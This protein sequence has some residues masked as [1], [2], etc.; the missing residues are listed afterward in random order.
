L[1]KSKPYII[2]SIIALLIFSIAFLIKPQAITIQLFFYNAL[3]SIAFIIITIVII[4]VLW[5]LLGGEPLEKLI[6]RF[7][8]IFE[9]LA[10]GFRSGVVRFASSS[11]NYAKADDWLNVLRHSKKQVEMLGYSLHIWTRTD[12]YA[13]ILIDLAKNGV[14]IRVMIMDYNNPHFT[15]G[16][17]FEQIKSITLDSMKSEVDICANYMNYVNAELIKIGKSENFSF[18]KCTKGLIQS[19]LCRMDEKLH[20]TPY[21]YSVNASSSPLFLIKGSSSDVFIKYENEF[22]S[23]W[24]LNAQ[25]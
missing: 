5:F 18:R 1:K 17:N 7:I 20:V 3:I 9:L 15:A 12:E 16:L 25:E 6:M 24:E 4:N 22:N 21:L 23:L 19:Q 13:K 8:D 10:D 2:L 11:S 14:K